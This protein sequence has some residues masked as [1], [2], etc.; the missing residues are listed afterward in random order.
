VDGHVEPLEVLPFELA[1]HNYV[2]DLKYS[3]GPG[4]YTSGAAPRAHP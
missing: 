1:E 3:F 2:F 4:Q